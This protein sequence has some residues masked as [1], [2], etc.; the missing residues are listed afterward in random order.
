MI[1]PFKN[2]Y[3]FFNYFEFCP[4]CNKRTS[5][6][7]TSSYRILSD[8]QTDIGVLGCRLTKNNCHLLDREDNI[9]LSINMIDNTVKYNN[10][11]KLLDCILI[12]FGKQCNKYHYYHTALATIEINSSLI[13]EIKLDKQHFIKQFGN[14]HFSVNSFFIDDQTSIRITGKNYVTKE[15][16]LPLVNF[17]L[18]SKKKISYKLKNIELLG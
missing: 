5:L 16:F 4:L 1:V 8:T 14:T 10:D 11:C 3:D 15:L 2:L 18:K 12:N 7:A 17:D 13:T 9:V 6:M